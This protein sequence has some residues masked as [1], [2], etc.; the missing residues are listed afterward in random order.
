MNNEVN[1]FTLFR[2]FEPSEQQRAVLALATDIKR[3]VDKERRIVKAHCTF[4]QIVDKDLLYEIEEGIKKAY[5]LNG[6]FLMPRY[7][8]ACFQSEYLHQVV[9]E[10]QRVGT[11]TR[12]FFDEYRFDFNGDK[13]EIVFHLPWGDGGISL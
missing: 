2:R 4:P 8:S 10:A 6:V 13:K 5:E 3:E 7:P 1:F 12:G 9:K 11:V